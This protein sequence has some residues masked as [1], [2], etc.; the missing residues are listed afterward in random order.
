MQ[1]WIEDRRRAAERLDEECICVHVRKR[2]RDGERKREIKRGE[3]GLVDAR[4]C[5]EGLQSRLQMFLII[6]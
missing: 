6:Q 5:S 4:G 3:L 1:A 2:E